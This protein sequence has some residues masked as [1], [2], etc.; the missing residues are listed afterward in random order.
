MV[1]NGRIRGRSGATMG[2]AMVA[3][4]RPW[5]TMDPAMADRGFGHGLVHVLFVA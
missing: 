2:Q 4:G 5:P 3:R 1:D